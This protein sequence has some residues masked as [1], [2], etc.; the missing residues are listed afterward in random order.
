MAMSRR[1]TKRDLYKELDSLR[2]YLKQGFRDP[3]IGKIARVARSYLMAWS[4]GS[5]TQLQATF[6]EYSGKNEDTHP[7]IAQISSVFAKATLH[8]TG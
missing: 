7:L 3:L 2:D 8:R 4:S 6:D 1:L 5:R